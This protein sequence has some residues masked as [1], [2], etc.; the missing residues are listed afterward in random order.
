MTYAERTLD[1]KNWPDTVS[2]VMQTFRIGGLGI[3]AVP[4]ET[5]TETRLEIKGKGPFQD[6][7]TIELAN[8]SYGY[9]PTPEQHELS[10]Y[11]T[12]LGPNRVEQEASRQ[13]RQIGAKLMELFQSVKP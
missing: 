4:V 3:T 13:I 12:W 6:T 8:G 1:A 7:F 9:L 10:G 5:F 11:E 2:I